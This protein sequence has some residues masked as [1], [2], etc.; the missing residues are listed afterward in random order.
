MKT[1]LIALAVVLVVGVFLVRR[2]SGFVV[3]TGNV[4]LVINHYSGKI[5]PNVRTAGFNAQAPF[6]G[7]ELVEVPTHQRTYTMVRDSTEGGHRGDDSVLVNTLSSNTLKVDVS[8]TYHIA[9]DPQHPERIVALYKKY[10][11]QFRDFA[12]FEEVQLRPAFR[13]AIV[14]AFGSATTSQ[15]M[16]GAGK[17]VASAFA[18]KQLNERFNDDSIVVDEVRIRAIYPD[19]ATVAALRSRL[20]AQQNLKLSQLNQQL[21]QLN[22]QRSVLKAEAEARAA[23]IRAASLTPRLV[24]FKHIKDIE[25]IGVPRGAIVNLPS[26]TS[27]GEASVPEPAQPAPQQAQNNRAEEGQ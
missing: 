17:R 11:S 23:Q 6:S 10:R 5:N 26:S 9:W 1:F 14:N 13:Q 21:Q 24:K 16:T 2:T 25:I 4:G 20:Q 8:I 18:L 7:N 27:G 12:A 15:N 3:K 22:N 19:E